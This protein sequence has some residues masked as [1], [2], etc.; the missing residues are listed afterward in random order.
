ML[1]GDF[2]WNVP[3]LPR[4]K[5]DK[6]TFNYGGLLCDLNAYVQKNEQFKKHPSLQDIRMS[7]GQ[8]HNMQIKETQYQALSILIRKH[9]ETE[10]NLPKSSLKSLQAMMGKPWTIS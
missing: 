8:Y 6:T 1:L 2:L 4:F 3:C 10:E 7:L 5:E 9:I